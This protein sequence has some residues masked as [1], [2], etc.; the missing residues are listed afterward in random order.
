MPTSRLSPPFLVFI[1]T[2]LT[3]ACARILI[4]SQTNNQT[5]AC[6]SVSVSTVP[7]THPSV[8]GDSP[9]TLLDS[10]CPARHWPASQTHFR[11]AW[12][13]NR[14]R[15][16]RHRGTGVQR[17]LLQL[18]APFPARP[19]SRAIQGK[20]LDSCLH[21]PYIAA[22]ATSPRLIPAIQPSGFV[23]GACSRLPVRLPGII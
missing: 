10:S 9:P 19:D 17:D 22:A 8:P 5:A 4:A 18:Q 23:D 16:D 11:R 1:I 2:A 7:K 12:T 14:P 6:I 20:G 13:G 3:F 15:T 21:P